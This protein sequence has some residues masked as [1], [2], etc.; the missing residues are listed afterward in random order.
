M[1]FSSLSYL[2]LAVYVNDLV[3]DVTSLFGFCLVPES[4]YSSGNVSKESS[5]EDEDKESDEI[6]K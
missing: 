6:S 5:E 3:D 2:S 4:D 1:G